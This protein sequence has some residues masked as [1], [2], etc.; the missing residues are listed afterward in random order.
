MTKLFEFSYKN[1]DRHEKM[2]VLIKI[3]HF[4]TVFIM[5]CKYLIPLQFIVKICKNRCNVGDVK[6]QDYTKNIFYMFFGKFSYFL[7]D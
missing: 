2:K 3:N 7:L 4:K 6:R 1:I 5:K